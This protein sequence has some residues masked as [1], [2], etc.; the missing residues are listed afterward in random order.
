MCLLPPFVYQDLKGNEEGF[1]V[2]ATPPFNPG[3]FEATVEEIERGQPRL[4][5]AVSSLDT[6]HGDLRRQRRERLRIVRGS[7]PLP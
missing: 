3:A 5:F 1:K 7:V 2:Q 6:E 4:Q